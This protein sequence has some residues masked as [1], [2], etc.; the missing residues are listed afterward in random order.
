MWLINLITFLGVRSYI[1]SAFLLR[2]CG[3][4]GHESEPQTVSKSR[5]RVLVLGRN[6]CCFTHTCV[7]CGEYICFCCWI[8]DLAVLKRP[9]EQLLIPPWWPNWLT[10]PPHF[11]HVLFFLEMPSLDL[12]HVTMSHLNMSI[13][14]TL[15]ITCFKLVNIDHAAPWD[16]KAVLP[17]LSL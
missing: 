6:E 17:Q 8:G 2:L 3:H 12:L 1:F 15:V 11:P 4:G 5:H 7:G 10:P 13:W 9:S 16:H 14:G